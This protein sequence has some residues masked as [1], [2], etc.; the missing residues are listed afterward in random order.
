MRPRSR[1]LFAYRGCLPRGPSPFWAK[2]GIMVPMK[3]PEPTDP[4]RSAEPGEVV[5]PV[6]RRRFLLGAT[7]AVVVAGVAGASGPASRA[8]AKSLGRTTGC[9][10]LGTTP[11]FRGI[12][13]SPESVLG[14]PL[15]SQEVT[16]AES[17][18]YIDAVAAASDQVVAGT[19]GMSVQGRELRYAIVGRPSNVTPSGLATIQAA[20]AQIRDPETDS[21]TV[22]ALAATTP[23][24]L[25]TIANIHGNEESGTDAALQVL[26][27]LADRD[28]CAADQI[29]DNAIVVIIPIQ[30]PDGR[31]ADTRRNANGFDLNRDMFARTQPET[32]T[33]VELMRQYPPLALTDSH[34][35]GYYQS[36]FP[37]NNDPVYAEVSRESLDWINGV[38][39]LEEGKKGELEPNRR[40]FSPNKPVRMKVPDRLV[41]HYFLADDPAKSREIQLLV[42]RLQRMDVQVFRLNAPITV[43]D[44]KPY[45][46]N[47]RKTMLAAGTYW[48]PM[49]QPQKHWI[50]MLLNE[51]SYPPTIFTYGLFGWSNALLM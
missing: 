21:A 28:D 39:A 9:D 33:K 43:S 36:F 40:I 49:A 1:R 45:A 17:S 34:E 15:G 42:R 37:P 27:E 46:R 47:R 31:E 4:G 3:P 11:T 41:R 26:Y 8:F 13:P 30:N 12:V 35:F 2:R 25:W 22:S 5:R 6:S 48:I 14:F 29:L 32:D 10:P 20:T 7:G 19:Y 50:Q 23:A 24:I 38:D 51:N 44:Y 16:S 18:T